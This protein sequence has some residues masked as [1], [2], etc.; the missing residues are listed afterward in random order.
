MIGVG[1][2]CFC[3]LVVPD[4]GF[5]GPNDPPPSAALMWTLFYSGFVLTGWGLIATALRFDWKGRLLL[6][7]PLM[8]FGI[9][10]LV[11]ALAIAHVGLVLLVFAFP[12]LI[13]GAV[14]GIMSL[15]SLYS[16]PY[17]QFF[18]FIKIEA[19]RARMFW[20]RKKIC[21]P[22]NLSSLTAFSVT[23]TQSGTAVCHTSRRCV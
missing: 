21:F 13:F 12:A 16:S 20:A 4:W 14:I 3:A 2:L 7:F 9:I 6:A 5:F 11:L 22:G 19:S 1:V 8:A 18:D 17:Q 10:T 23:D 15:L